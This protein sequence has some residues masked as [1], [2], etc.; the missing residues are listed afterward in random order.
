MFIKFNVTANKLHDNGVGDVSFE[1]IKLGLQ[2]VST[3]TRECILPFALQQF[4]CD[5]ISM[6]LSIDTP[7]DMWTFSPMHNRVVPKSI[8][9]EDAR[10]QLQHVANL[11]ITP[12]GIVSRNLF[13]VWVVMK[14]VWHNG[15]S[16]VIGFAYRAHLLRDHWILMLS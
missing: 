8:Q 1:M 6:N 12:S 9:M 11:F 7:K 2:I 5:I 4:I 13:Q 15:S 16:D 3:V 14:L 10:L